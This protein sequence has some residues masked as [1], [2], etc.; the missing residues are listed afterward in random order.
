MP[1]SFS[2]FSQILLQWYDQYGRKDLPWQ[3]PRT[4]FRVWISEVM[5][6]QT[7]VKTV[8]PYFLRFIERFPDIETLASASE[9]DV[10]AHWSG[11]GYYSRARNIHRTAKIIESEHKGHFPNQLSTLLALPGIGE[12]TA[13]AIA[14]LAF[15]QSTAI[16]D[17]N[18]KRVLSRYFLVEP[19][20]DPSTMKQKLWQ[21]AKNCMPKTQCADYTQ[22]IMDMGATCCTTKQPLCITCPLNVHCL[23]YKNN[24]VAQYP[25]KPLKKI[26]PTKQEQFLLLH[27]HDGMIYLEKRPSSGIWGG[28]WCLPTIDSSICPKEYV[29]HTYQLTTTDP[30]KILEFKHTFTHYHLDI[31]AWSLFTDSNNLNV[32]MASG[33]WFSAKE[34]SSV[35]LAK[36]VT[37]IIDY[38]QN[39]P[40]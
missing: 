36:P 2:Q 32:A 17:G 19:T 15:N 9:D 13:A 29:Q 21:L 16:L 30:K 39:L 38:F 35:G 8:I 5:L 26:R 12:S 20:I 4:A 34:M 31:L 18:V 37:R 24:V 28:L 7:Q 33:R 1:D 3:H 40:C 23:A 6:Q 14:S 27:T 10:L 25:Y 11:L 22:A